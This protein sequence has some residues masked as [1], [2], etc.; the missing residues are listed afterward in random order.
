MDPT[1][2][3]AGTVQRRRRDSRSAPIVLE[4]DVGTDDKSGNVSH[5]QHVEDI[6]PTSRRY[7]AS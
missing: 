1:V 6:L 7:D 4:V 3:L 5:N 2:A